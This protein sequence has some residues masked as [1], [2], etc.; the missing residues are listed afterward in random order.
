MI[1]SFFD[2]GS[3]EEIFFVALA[4]DVLDDS[5]QFEVELSNAQEL[6]EARF[7]RVVVVNCFDL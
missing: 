4:D 5:L 1:V 2:G 6:F 3:G 7:E